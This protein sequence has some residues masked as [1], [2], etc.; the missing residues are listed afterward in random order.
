MGCVVGVAASGAIACSRFRSKKIG[1]TGARVV[2]GAVTVLMLVLASRPLWTTVHRGTT[3]PV[4]IFTNSVVGSFQKSQGLPVDPT[5]T[6]AESTI[7]WVSYYLTWPV[8]LLAFLGLGLATYYAVRGRGGWAVLLGATLAPS[9]LYFWKPEIVPDQVWAIR[10]FEPMT[11]PA[12]ALAATLAAVW[13]AKR[14]AR[15][16]ASAHCA[17]LGRVGNGAAAHRDVAHRDAGRRRIPSAA[18]RPSWCAR[19]AAR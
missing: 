11:I 18:Q 7:N 9:L 17:Q 2:G 3:D 5:R 16:S 15:S 19:W 4:D 6:Y 13:L 12:F 1:E 10:R 14:L 8:V